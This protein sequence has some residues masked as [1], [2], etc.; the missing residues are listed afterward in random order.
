MPVA[1]NDQGDLRH[2]HLR[3]RARRKDRAESSHRLLATLAWRLDGV[4]AYAL[5]GSIFTSG[6]AVQWLRDGIGVIATAPK[7]SHWHGSVADTGG[8]VVV[9]AFTGMGAP[10]WRADVAG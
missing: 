10:H 2:R 6:A 9:P 4:P 5:E 7:P 8:V 3:P 1:G